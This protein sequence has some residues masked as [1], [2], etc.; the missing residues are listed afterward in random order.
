MQSLGITH[1]LVLAALVALVLDSRRLNGLAR[2]RRGRRPFTSGRGI[3]AGGDPDRVGLT[4]R[5]IQ[6]RN[7]GLVD[8]DTSHRAA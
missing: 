1:F 5:Q 3:P 8:A 6:M 7:G 4:L 2:W